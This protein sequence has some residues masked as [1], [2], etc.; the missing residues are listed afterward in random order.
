MSL[1]AKMRRAP[2][3][4]VTGAY[5]LNSG[6]GKLSTDDDTAKK[7]HGMASGTY[8]FLDNMQ[9]RVFAKTLGVGEIAVGSVL[10]LPIVPPVVAGAALLG[11][12]GALLNM[13]W[14]TPG[15]HQEGNPRPTAAGTPIA[16]DIWMLG[17]GTGLITDAMLEPA[18]NKRLEVGATVA[19]KRA[20][21]SRRAKRKAA[22]AA[23]EASKRSAEH[24]AH[25]KAMLA[26]AQEQASK[27]AERAAKRAKKA[28]ER[29]QHASDAAGKRL[30]EF[31][32]HAQD[33]AV[34]VKERVAS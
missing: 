34:R 6:V 31:A 30:G 15:L 33:A 16:K 21:K 26:D 18:H 24:V 28:K 14:R 9:P 7:L 2:L 11:F 13:Y 22:K 17:I 20:A 10:L 12:S 25:G 3:R 19:E 4:A 27:H 29:A 8:G 5:I 32:S 1:S 23:A